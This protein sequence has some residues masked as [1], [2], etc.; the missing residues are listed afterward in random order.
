MKT[1]F[2][3]FITIAA[4]ASMA[5]CGNTHESSDSS[6]RLTV[7]EWNI[8]HAG[9]LKTYG[10]EA[11]ES[12]IGIL[13]KSGADVILMVETYGSSTQV[14]DSLGF[15]HR[16]I[17]DNL[18]IYSRYPIVKTYIFPDSISTFNFGGV[19]IDMDGTPV[20]LF[21]TW[22]H[23]LPDARL[24]P[25]DLSEEEIIAWENSG[26]RD[27]ETR[28]ILTV[29]RPMIAQSDSIPLIM[30]GDFNSHSHLD[31]IDSTKN[32]YKHGGAVVNW[33]V[34]RM[35]CEA[36]FSDSFREI[37]PDPAKNIGTTWL[38]EADSLETPDRSDRIDF[39]YYTGKT[40]KAVESQCY[41][42]KLWQP[43]SFR[44]ATFSYPSD[45]GFVLTTFEI[46]P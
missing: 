11:C 42:G 31:W 14:A 22:I 9:H 45:H 18:S 29:L 35:M 24:A 21:D 12:T 6:K 2:N 23:Y 41:D 36:G 38:T 16:L 34:S 26:T 10:P 15:Y 5:S 19:E 28:A 25:V 27:E 8:W 33:P 13:R 30:G 1:V 3:L 7:L 37:N 39:I 17:S 32:M 43:F 4:A 20:R 40:I 46:K 44:G